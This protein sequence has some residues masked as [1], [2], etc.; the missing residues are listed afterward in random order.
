[1]LI[2]ALQNSRFLWNSVAARQAVMIGSDPA[3]LARLAFLGLANLSL[4]KTSV[5]NYTMCV[6]VIRGPCMFSG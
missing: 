2:G 4:P 3:G 5:V 6:F 1:M